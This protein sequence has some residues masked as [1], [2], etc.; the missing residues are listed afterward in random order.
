MTTWTC[1]ELSKIGAAEELQTSLG[2]PRLAPDGR[3]TGPEASPPDNSKRQ[4]RAWV[5]QTL[6]H[7]L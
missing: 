4:G 3:D 2:H 7:Q 6:A 5:R 1:N